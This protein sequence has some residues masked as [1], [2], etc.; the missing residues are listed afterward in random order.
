MNRL[1]SFRVIVVIDI[2]KHGCEKNTF[3][4]SSIV[5]MGIYIFFVHLHSSVSFSRIDFKLGEKIFKILY[6]N[7]TQKINFMKILSA[8]NPIKTEAM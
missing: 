1:I 5:Y 7:N 3:K 6:Y 2:I 4:V 8:T